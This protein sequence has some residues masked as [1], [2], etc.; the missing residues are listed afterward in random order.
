MSFL[1]CINA[2]SQKVFNKKFNYEFSY[3][4]INK[5]NSILNFEVDSVPSNSFWVKRISFKDSIFFKK[6]T[7]NAYLFPNERINVYEE[8]KLG[9]CVFNDIVNFNRATFLN[10]LII[11]YNK[12]NKFFDCNGIKLKKYTQIQGN[13]FYDVVDLSYGI[14]GENKNDLEISKDITNL[15]GN[16]FLKNV[17]F[18]GATFIFPLTFESVYNSGEPFIST[19]KK[20]VNFNQC[21]F[22]KILKLEGTIFGNKASFDGAI[23][24]D[25]VFT[26]EM[27]L[28]DTLILSNIQFI[29]KSIHFSQG[30]LSKN[31]QFCYVN[32]VGSD[33]NKFKIDYKKFRLYFPAE[34]DDNQKCAVYEGLLKNF[35]TDG[36][37]SSYKLLDIEYQKYK[38]KRDERYFVDWVQ[39][40]WWNYGYNK[41]KIFI[42]SIFLLLLFFFINL[43]ITLFKGAEYLMVD[44][45]RVE[46]LWQEVENLKSSAISKF[47][48]WIR[49]LPI[50][51]IYT[52]MIFFVL[53][54]NIKYL[55]FSKKLGLIYVMSIFLTGLL[56]VAY[57]VN[58]ILDK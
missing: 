25:I 7:F 24:K 28:P 9:Y 53:N 44:V 33:I 52:S 23:F 49:F 10:D 20:D 40:W 46:G 47:K 48:Y 13:I 21:T 38:N 22:N 16:S 36:L 6:D 31:K 2:F 55:R 11:G 8:F 3:S 5:L 1:F 27:V 29:E 34:T 43:I 12:F 37:T 51:L 42:N 4:N 18:Q 14:F 54:L 39:S 45:Y 56:C 32:L 41:E 30:V 58:F 15:I 26:K 57:I 19:F 35:Q 50:L 17:N